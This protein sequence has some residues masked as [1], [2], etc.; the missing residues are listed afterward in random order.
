M[1]FENNLFLARIQVDALTNDFTIIYSIFLFQK[2]FIEH[3]CTGICKIR[4]LFPLVHLL[5]G[6]FMDACFLTFSDFIKL[7]ITSYKL[8]LEYFCMYED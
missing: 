7:T 1:Q 5:K 2:Y 6:N 3:L 4:R 8:Q